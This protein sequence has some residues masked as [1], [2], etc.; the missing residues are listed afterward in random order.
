MQFIE[1]TFHLH[2]CLKRRIEQQFSPAFARQE[3]FAHE[4]IATGPADARNNLTWPE[5]P[6]G[7]FGFH[8]ESLMHLL[9][10]RLLRAIESPVETLQL[11]KGW[12][13]LQVT[14]CAIFVQAPD[15]QIQVMLWQRDDRAECSLLKVQP[16]TVMLTE[17]PY[18][19]LWLERLEDLSVV[20]ICRFHERQGL[21]LT[22]DAAKKYA[23]WMFQRFARR[24]HQ[25]V[26]LRRM[27]QRC[28]QALNLK[29]ELFQ[30]AHRLSLISKA[31]RK[32]SM[33]DYNS[34][35]QHA[36]A[37]LKL[38]QDSPAMLRLYVALCNQPGFPAQGEPLARIRQHLRVL[39][40]SGNVWRLAVK[41]GARLLLPMREFYSS[42]ARESVNDYLCILEQLHVE[43]DDTPTALRLLFSEFGHDNARRTTYWP[44]LQPHQAAFVHL[45]RVIRA[46]PPAHLPAEGQT[47]VVVRWIVSKN[48]KGWN[49]AQR[50]R[51]WPWL[52]ASAQ[53]WQTFELSQQ[54][55]NP[56]QWMVPFGTLVWAGLTFTALK[57]AAD[58]I[59]EGHQMRNCAAT[60][61]GFCLAGKVLLVAV[62]LA[63][64]KRIAT[65]SFKRSAGVWRLV[66]VKGPA[67]RVLK[68]GFERLID[69]FSKNIPNGIEIKPCLPSM[70]DA[71][72]EGNHPYATNEEFVGV[73]DTNAPQYIGTA[74]L[75]GAYL[76]AEG[77]YGEIGVCDACP[78][79]GHA[80]TSA[81]HADQ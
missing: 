44:K 55:A 72:H 70:A 52:L 16:Q 62:A 8:S 50:Q 60:Y 56:T 64:G 53:A 77:A 49:R 5:P 59:L 67:N 12:R 74:T 80:I 75:P 65:A 17:T 63:T 43:A 45:L 38:Q 79:A 21:V 58:L 7:H 24:L 42:G 18:R 14:G 27:R 11:T 26:D 22:I 13:A 54:E 40:F 2:P 29:A 51:G 31:K 69:Q 66:S 23:H 4:E 36:T 32:A 20:S 37:I 1:M 3:L 81:A 30:A 47:A 35:V 76:P 19:M 48:I 78:S 34:A 73:P 46:L 15:S 68:P 33:A 28:A 10:T 25:H 71:K 41:K 57:N 61:T 6:T 9:W 39:N